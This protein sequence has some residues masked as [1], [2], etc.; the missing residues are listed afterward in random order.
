MIT[1][2]FSNI[3]K[4]IY[5]TKIEMNLAENIILD[6]KNLKKLIKHSRKNYLQTQNHE[7]LLK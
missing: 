2:N 1:Y 3:G 7:N 5:K 6:Y 4:I